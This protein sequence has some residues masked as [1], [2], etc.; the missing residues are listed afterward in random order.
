MTAQ[1][2]IDATKPLLSQTS[3]STDD[4]TLLI[5]LNM[6]KNQ[7]AQDTLSW[8]G[9]EEITMTTESVYE[10]DNMPIQILDVYDESLNTLD[11]NSYSQ[12]GYF[13]IS[14]MEIKVNNPSDGNKLYI[15]YYYTP[16]DYILT[17]DV[18]VPATLQN[19]IQYFIAHKS[20]ET[21]RS[22][23][24]IFSSTEYYKKYKASVI[25]YLNTTDSLNADSLVKK[26]MI[27]DKCLV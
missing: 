25:E 3:V 8:L 26:D 6:A 16:N 20:F 17:D 27:Q 11:R 2:L 1:S 12:N 21:Y 23:K 24:E 13:Q 9:G 19:A 22:E 10:L 15:N 4:D 14:P 7:I 18:V 5:F